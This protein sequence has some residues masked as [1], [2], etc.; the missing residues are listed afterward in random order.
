MNYNCQDFESKHAYAIAIVCYQGTA[1][2]K[3]AKP[4][5]YTLTKSKSIKEVQWSY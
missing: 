2:R 1:A 3:M 4:V 5:P